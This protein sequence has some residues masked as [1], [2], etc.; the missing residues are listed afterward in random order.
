MFMLTKAYLQ[1]SCWFFCPFI[2]LLLFLHATYTI[3]TSSI[4][5]NILNC[6][7]LGNL[8]SAHPVSGCTCVGRCKMI[9]WVKTI[10]RYL[11]EGKWRSREPK[12]F[13]LYECLCMFFSP[14]VL[15]CM[16]AGVFQCSSIMC[17]WLP[18]H[19]G[20]QTFGSLSISMPSHALHSTLNRIAISFSHTQADTY[21]HTHRYSPCFHLH[22]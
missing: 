12:G 13:V 3:F 6:L 7:Y 1:W 18:P 22:E 14:H 15:H 17:R 9:C 5:N 8:K 16:F 20:T 2:Y 19:R 21:P 11:V 10:F 4:K